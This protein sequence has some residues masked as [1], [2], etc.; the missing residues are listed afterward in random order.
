MTFC[1]P[2]RAHALRNLIFAILAC[3]SAGY[4]QESIRPSSTGEQ[5]AHFRKPSDLPL[6][7]NMK[8]GPVVFDASAG[9]EVEFNDN[10]GISE[11]NR[12]SDVIFR[13]AI[14]VDSMWRVSRLNTIRFG[15]GVSVA[16]YMNESDLNSN[17]ILLDP[18]TQLSFDLYIG[19]ALRLN[20]HDRI[21]IVQNP[22]DEITVSNAARFDRLQNQAGVTAFW[23]LNDLQLTF[24]YDHFDYHTFDDK[25]EFLDRR[26][27]QFFGSAALILDPAYTVG[28]DAHAALV[29]YVTEYNNNGFTYGGGPFLDATLSAYSKLR[30]A[31][32]YQGMSFDGD[33]T[34][35]DSTDYNGWYANI[36]LAQRLNSHWSHS[37]SVGHEARLGLSVN[38][39]EYTFA[40]Y[41]A[42]WRLN[43]RTNVTIEG[44]VEDAN[45]SGDG[46][47]LS[48]HAFRWGAGVG[49]S[50]RIGQ[51]ITLSLR[52]RYVNK[53]SDLDLRS[54]YQNIGTLNV[55]WDF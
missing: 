22:V 3:T 44:F 37:V 28:L 19:D 16:R 20:F 25:F 49:L 32:G 15:L 26:E 7:Y 43:T 55:M 29:N 10:V 2:S 48:E 51:N 47:L 8:A 14:E 1:L 39:A 11:N 36:A 45:E 27:E 30:V 54:Y 13:P 23:D 53:D 40:R 38:F 50:R 34:S 46:E 18:G 6:K 52:Y 5:A 17:S 21:A 35:G 4:A 12:E 41:V 31:A 9:L 33:G 24:G 42:D